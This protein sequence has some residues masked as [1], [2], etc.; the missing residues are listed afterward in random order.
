MTSSVRLFRSTTVEQ[1]VYDEPERRF[2]AVVASEVIEHVDN[3]QF[4]VA[5]CASL[6]NPG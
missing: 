5:T 6:L 2:D 1:L 3:P 4:F